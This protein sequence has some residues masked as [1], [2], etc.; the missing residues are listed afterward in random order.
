MTNKKSTFL[1]ESYFSQYQQ[2]QFLDKILFNKKKNG[3]FIDIGAHDGVT[4]SNSLF[5]EKYRDWKGICIEPNPVVYNQLQKNRSSV[6]LNVCIGNSN[7][8][9]N[10]T[11]ILGYSEMLSGVTSTYD[12]RHLDRI[13]SE[14]SQK[15][16]E[17]KSIDVQMLRLDAIEGILDKKIDF[18]SIDTEGNEIDIIKSIDFEKIFIK[19][20]VVENNYNDTDLANLLKSKN[21]NLITTL[22]TDEVYINRKEFTL[23]VKYNLFIWNS[24]IIFQIFLKLI[25]SKLKKL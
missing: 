19:V 2:D 11:Q 4:I 15:G 12:K 5:F 7:K 17:I 1:K 20:L 22:H 10:F 21:F 13:N 16:G 9:V 14:V 25:K 6:N 23:W 18:V 24:K 3:F 8:I